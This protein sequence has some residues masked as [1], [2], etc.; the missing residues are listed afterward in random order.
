M[1]YCT[2]VFTFKDIKCFEGVVQGV[3]HLLLVVQFGGSLLFLS[4]AHLIG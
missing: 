2:E 3:K 1:W 4:G